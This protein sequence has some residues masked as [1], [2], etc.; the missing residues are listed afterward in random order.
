VANDIKANLN[1]NLDVLCLQEPY[2]YMGRVRGYAAN[3]K[4]IIQ[5]NTKC[6]MAAIVIYNDEIEITQL[7]IAGEH[8][9]AVQ[10]L[11]EKTEIFL[12]NAY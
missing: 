4:K 8:V 3:N 9:V 11:L 1:S 5:P 7:N 12:V 2:S 6:P 10:I